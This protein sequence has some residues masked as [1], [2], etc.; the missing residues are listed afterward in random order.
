MVRTSSARPVATT[1]EAQDPRREALAPMALKEFIAD[2]TLE[3]RRLKKMHDRRWGRRR[4]RWRRS[5]SSS[6][7]VRAVVS[8]P[9]RTRRFLQ[10]AND[11]LFCKPLALHR[12]SFG[13]NFNRSWRKV[14]GSRHVPTTSS[15]TA[16]AV[17]AR[18]DDL[19]QHSGLDLIS[20]RNTY[21]DVRGFLPRVRVDPGATISKANIRSS[22]SWKKTDICWRAAFSGSVSRPCL[23]CG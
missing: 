22:A 5:I 8:R 9:I 1:G 10:H 13:P 18:A 12:L 21:A 11:L 4:L 6:S 16:K 23:Y 2:L 3:N 19:A 14:R 7:G 17:Q 15:C 20:A